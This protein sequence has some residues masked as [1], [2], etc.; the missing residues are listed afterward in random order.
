[1]Y[2][3]RIENILYQNCNYTSSE[4]NVIVDLILKSHF[5]NMSSINTKY[6]R[7]IKL[8]MLMLVT[9]D[10]ILTSELAHL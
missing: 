5:Q 9:I 4:R 7:I 6:H 8:Y 3:N 2:N 10:V 1:M